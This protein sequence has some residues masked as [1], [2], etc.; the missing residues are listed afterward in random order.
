MSEELTLDLFRNKR[1]NQLSITI[2]KKK[3]KFLPNVDK[4]KKVKIKFEFIK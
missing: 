4:A 1:N 3:V 2:P